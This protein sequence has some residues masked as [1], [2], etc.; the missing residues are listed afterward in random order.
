MGVESI[1]LREAAHLVKRSVKYWHLVG[2]LYFESLTNP[3]SAKVFR[4]AY[5]FCRHIDDVLDGDRTI[6]TDPR[7]YVHDILSAMK[8]EHQGSPIVELYRFAIGPIKE[9]AIEADDP[10]SYFVRVIR[11]AMLFDFERAKGKRVLTNDEIEQY[12]DDTFTPVTNIA[13]IIAGSQQRTGDVP[14]MVTTQGHIYTIRDMKKDLG[15]GIINIPQEELERAGVSDNSI[16]YELVRRN[17]QLFSWMNDEVRT[18][19]EELRVI[20]GKLSDMASRKVCLPLIWQMNTYCK[21]YQ[22]GHFPKFL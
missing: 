13:L 10:E 16:S 4:A 21:L 7:D 3:H 22:L 12:Y 18:Y 6:T 14:E 5:F 15:Q 9:M 19:Q 11:D 20:R 8:N 1:C 2:K 17:P